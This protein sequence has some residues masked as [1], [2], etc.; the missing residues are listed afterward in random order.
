MINKN[1]ETRGNGSRTPWPHH[2]PHHP[3]VVTHCR[4]PA[5]ARY[6]RSIAQSTSLSWWLSVVTG[7]IVGRGVPRRGSARAGS[8]R[9]R[10]NSEVWSAYG[11]LLVTELQPG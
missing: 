4:D 7:S 2:L 3:T 8:E 9:Y 10:V 1:C 11:L 5:L 6:R